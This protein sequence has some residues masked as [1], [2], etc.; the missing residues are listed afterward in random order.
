MTDAVVEAL[1]GAYLAPDELFELTGRRQ[2]AK[3]VAWLRRS[4]WRYAID[5]AGRPLVARDYWRRRMV[6]GDTAEATAGPWEPQF[7]KAAVG[8]SRPA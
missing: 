7:T 6:E 4:H 1:P 3:Q 2:R 8:V 5:A